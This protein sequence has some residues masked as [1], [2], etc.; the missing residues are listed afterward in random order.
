[1]RPLQPPSRPSWA[2]RLPSPSSLTYP[3]SARRG[4]HTSTHTSS[5]GPAG[6][7]ED[8][9]Q[10]PWTPVGDLA[11]GLRARPAAAAGLSPRCPQQPL[12]V[13]LTPSSTSLSLPAPT[14][15]GSAKPCPE[16]PVIPFLASLCPV[17]CLNTQA[18][19]LSWGGLLPNSEATPRASRTVLGTRTRLRESLGDGRGQCQ[20]WPR[21][22]G[23]GVSDEDIKADGTTALDPVGALRG[24]PVSLLH[25]LSSNLTPQQKHGR[26][27]GVL[28]AAQG[29]ELGGKVA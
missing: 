2:R 17:F 9:P 10:G 4:R 14:L 19:L 28:V 24:H 11:S 1:M 12:W 15:L 5:R 3:R 8:S 13:P 6:C 20:S 23:P 21:G 22:N 7:E 25:L 18:E 16:G 27:G 29:Q 26:L